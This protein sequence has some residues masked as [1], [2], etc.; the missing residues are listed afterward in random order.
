MSTVKSTFDFSSTKN[1][2][3]EQKRAKAIYPIH[4]THGRRFCESCRTLKPKNG[5]PHVKGW[6]CDDCERGED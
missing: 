5:K 4:N 1:L 2:E 3:I 6:K